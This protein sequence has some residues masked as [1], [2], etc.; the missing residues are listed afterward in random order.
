M[1]SF[2]PRSA[3][4]GHVSR[5]CQLGQ[6]F[7]RDGVVSRLASGHAQNIY[8]AVT[9][10]LTNITQTVYLGHVTARPFLFGSLYSRS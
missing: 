5:P 4:T 7:F 9:W 6:L 2:T 8:R 1:F 10:C 3:G